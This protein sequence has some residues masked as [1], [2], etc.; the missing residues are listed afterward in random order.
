MNNENVIEVFIKVGDDE[1]PLCLKII[2]DNEKKT[3]NC[4]HNFCLSCIDKW[5]NNN[6]LHKM[7]PLCECSVLKSVEQLY[8]DDT[9]DT[10][11]PINTCLEFLDFEQTNSISLPIYAQTYNMLRII[12][13]MGGLSYSN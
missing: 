12:S 11:D 7:C 5:I 6:M 10:I 4:Q 8:P 1:C 3:L 2:T 13:G 9:I